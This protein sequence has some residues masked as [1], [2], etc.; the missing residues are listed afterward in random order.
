MTDAWSTDEGLPQ[1]T[2]TALAQTGDG[3]LWIG[4]LGGLARF[5][6][7]RFRVYTGRDG[8]PSQRIL[9]LLAAR[10]G[11]LWVGT[12]G[13]GVVRILGG[14]FTSFTTAQGLAHDRVTNMAED[15]A[16]RIWF[17]TGAGLTMWQAG[18]FT[19][20]RS[21][22][23]ALGAGPIA[24]LAAGPTGEV[25]VGTGSHVCQVDGGIPTCSLLDR[26]LR[27]NTIMQ[28]RSGELWIGTN[29]S[30]VARW[31]REHTEVIPACDG[32]TCVPGAEVWAFTTARP[33][34]V[35]VA[36]NRG[37]SR[38]RDGQFAHY[39]A[40]NGLP[41]SLVRTVFV[42]REANLWAGTNDA[43]LLRLKPRRLTVCGTTNDLASEVVTTVAEDAAG[44]MW[45][46]SNCGGLRTIAAG[47]VA[48]VEPAFAL[49]TR[50][51]FSFG[52]SR[53]GGPWMGTWGEGLLK[54]HGRTPTLYASAAELNS[55]AVMAIHED[56]QGGVW[57]GTYDGPLVYLRGTERR[58]FTTSDGVAGTY[59]TSIVEQADGTIW[60][61]SNLGGLTRIKDG[62]LT[63]FNRDRGLG[64]DAVR[65]L[66]VDRADT[67]WIGTGD[68]GLV[69]YANERFVRYDT[70][71]GLADNNVAQILED[72]HGDL[73]IGSGY[74]IS[75]LSRRE[76]DAVAEGRLATL[77]VL[78]LGRGDGLTR[79]EAVG[80]HAPSAWRSANGHLWFATYGGLVVIDPTRMSANEASPSMAIDSVVIDGVAHDPGAFIRVP[81]GSRSLQI[82]YAA[83][84]LV[85]PP[86]NRFRYRLSGWDREWMEVGTDRTAECGGLPPGRYE[87]AVLG[88]NSDG[89]WSLAPARVVLEFEPYVWQRWWFRSALIL[90]T[91]VGFALAFRMAANAKVRREVEAL[92]RER[93][94]GRERT[95]IARDMHDELGARLTNAAML[96]DAVSK[97]PR[98]TQV[99]DAIRQAVMAMDQTVWAVNPRNDSLENFA[100]Y[101]SKYAHEFL[102]A[103]S[104]HCRLDVPISLPPVALASQ[105][106]HGLLM[107]VKEALTNIVKHAHATEA[108]F[109]VR[110]D[111]KGA[112]V[113]EV[114]DNGTGM[115]DGPGRSH[116]HGLTNMRERMA[117]IGGRFDLQA[118]E[119]GT[120]VTLTLP[121]AK[122]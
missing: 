113:I 36:T 15:A 44:T 25:W 46:G 85:D 91:V 119:H 13:S 23:G 83:L 78:T 52:R 64:S 18:N 7:V 22:D 104:V 58:R 109:R 76:I 9:S 115:V 74:G 75:R 118:G 32:P 67:L 81:P 120:T 96:A 102:G 29:G 45:I 31:T 106:R 48:L 47:R 55:S 8:L 94:I 70:S 107:V 28:H 80:D 100:S 95:R 6:G 84:S 93:A 50:C 24:G 43:G 20:L 27:T 61:G 87:F 97:E 98:F 92:D 116:R 42:D 39:S 56:R 90:A 63:A 112:I 121:G 79:T 72:L 110:V 77:N 59:H 2:V 105:D 26:R 17:A 62:H 33:D 89:V 68:G 37:L 122:R 101:A 73:W 35:W 108:W 4:T 49:L 38:W 12:E 1:S 3:Y 99:S 5:D 111:D 34:D 19:T 57:L 82:R 86:R 53:E 41:S 21:A 114:S 11:A 88:S 16:G 69:S 66:L 103:T 60:V 51:V 10:D 14:R 71:R 40:G 117:S 54:W 30:G 65:A